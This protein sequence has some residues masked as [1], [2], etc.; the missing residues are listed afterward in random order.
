MIY[1]LITW[2]ILQASEDV[3]LL[4][5]GAGELGLRLCSAS[6]SIDFYLPKTLVKD[7][8]EYIEAQ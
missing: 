1:I 8:S 6:D 4:E 5:R 2:L 7:N 3:K